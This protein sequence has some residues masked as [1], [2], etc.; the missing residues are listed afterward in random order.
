[1]KLLILLFIFIAYS[2]NAHQL[3]ENYLK[4]D[5]DDTTR[6]LQ[7][8]LKIET[9]L[10]ENN[11]SIDDNKN[12]IVSFKELR[13]HQDYLVEYTD[14]H[15]NLFYVDKRLSILDSKVSF[16]RYQ[17]QTYMTITKTF[18]EINLDLLVLK[19]NM[20]FELEDIHKLLIHL[21]DK[22]GDYIL[23][24]SNTEYSFSSLRMSEVQRLY[25]FVKDGISHIL[26]G[27]D[28]LLFVLMLLIPTVIALHVESE[29]QSLKSLGLSLFKIITAFSVA[30]SIT[31]FIS[32]MGLWAPNI[33]FIESSIAFTI[34][35][36]ALMNFL[37]KYNHVNYKIVFLFGLLHGFGFANV[38]E[39]AQM[40]SIFSFLVALFGFNFG[41]ELGQIFV[42]SLVLPFLYF[43]A[44]MKY[45][46]SILK[47]VSFSAMLLAIVWFFQ[48][49]GLL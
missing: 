11:S 36:V 43:V 14:K 9:R 24:K 42:I 32:A 48:R 34:F 8:T 40:D 46:V 16:D 23:D 33:K 47:I 41:V 31:L 7:M 2:L 15:F 22:R 13:A 29:N 26:D 6:V 30:H 20:F 19:Y 21:G 27:L 38:L 49:T 37:G 12:E 44:K 25:I 18:N 4:V 35:V 28:H 39:I 45:C 5:F 17:D 3:R 10:L 1:M